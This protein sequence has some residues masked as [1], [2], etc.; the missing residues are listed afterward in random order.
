M[1]QQIPLCILCKYPENITIKIC[2]DIQKNLNIPVFIIS[3]MFYE[4]TDK[5][6]NIIHISDEECLKY[7][8]RNANYVIKK[9]CSAWD[10]MLY[11]FTKV[12]TDYSFI[13]V[14]EDDVFVPSINNFKIMYETYKDDNTDHLATRIKKIDKNVYW[15]HNDEADFFGGLYRSFNPMCRLSKRLIQSTSNFIIKYNRVAFI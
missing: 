10:K 2:N 6:I 11:Y 15:F 1:S 14:L 12:Y 8:Y 3:D 7:N 9:E 13:W 5:N 4:S